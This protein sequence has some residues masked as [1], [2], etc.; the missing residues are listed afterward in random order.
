M[1]EPA[2]SEDQPAGT[3]IWGSGGHRG[4]PRKTGALGGQSQRWKRECR[5]RPR[6][7]PQVAARPVMGHRVGGSGVWRG[8]PPQPL[9]DL[10]SGVFSGLH[11]SHFRV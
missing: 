6:V 11:L 5:T 3:S 10:L 7:E 2:K 9:C 8:R 4:D 1:V